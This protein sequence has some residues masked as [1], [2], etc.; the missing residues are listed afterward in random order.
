MSV[1]RAKA[2]VGLT[3]RR[4]HKRPLFARADSLKASA[5]VCTSAVVSSCVGV[6]KCSFIMAVIAGTSMPRLRKM[7]DVGAGPLL[8]DIWN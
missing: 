5:S 1:D 7:E 3:V 2:S 4:P 8:M 6:F